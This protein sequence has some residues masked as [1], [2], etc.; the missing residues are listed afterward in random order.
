M[1]KL[2]DDLPK[3][4]LG[5]EVSGKVTHEDYKTFLIPTAEAM[6]ASGPLTMLFVIGQDFTGYELEAMWDDGTFGLRHWRQ[7]DRVAVVADHAWV[8]AAVTMFRPFL[9]AEVRLFKNAELAAAKQWIS[10]EKKAP[11]RT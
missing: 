7:F 9:P 11:S 2:L 5:I 8:R 6:L 10:S 3:N 4:V 1:M